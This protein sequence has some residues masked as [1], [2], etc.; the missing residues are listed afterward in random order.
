MGGTSNDSLYGEDGSDVLLGGSSKDKLYGGIGRDVLYGE[1][2][3]DTLDGRLGVDWLYGGTGNDTYIVDDAND[4]ISD[5]SRAEGD[6]LKVHGSTTDYELRPSLLFG[7][8]F[9][10]R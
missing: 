7:R 2:E 1:A 10:Q 8:Y 3:D 6:K 9:V 5:F 4:Y